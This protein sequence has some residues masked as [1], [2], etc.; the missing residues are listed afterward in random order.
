MADE[1]RALLRRLPARVFNGEVHQRELGLA[2]LSLLVHGRLRLTFRHP[3]GDTKKTDDLISTEPCLR[4]KGI[5]ITQSWTTM[6]P[7]PALERIPGG[8]RAAWCPSVRRSICLPPPPHRRWSCGR[9]RWFPETCSV[10]GRWGWRGLLWGWG[11]PPGWRPRGQARTNERKQVCRKY[12]ENF[13]YFEECRQ[14][15]TWTQNGH[16]SKYRRV[17]QNEPSNAWTHLYFGLN[18]PFKRQAGA[19]FQTARSHRF[20]LEK[21]CHLVAGLALVGLTLPVV[22]HVV[23]VCQDT[24]QQLFGT[25]HHM[26][27]W[28]KWPERRWDNEFRWAAQVPRA[29][30]E[31]VMSR[32][33]RLEVGRIH[34]IALI[35][36]TRGQLGVS[37]SKRHLIYA[38]KPAVL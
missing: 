26:F 11:A 18:W 25:P 32:L 7:L 3:L 22:G 34:Q 36:L 31:N 12:S 21:L 30:L 28:N 37:E 27:V 29:R 33:K 20:V 4:F 10:G 15:N 14:P 13:R 6:K 2:V 35:V 1:H 9:S 8:C 16:F 38:V 5:K 24:L 17:P 23:D 19:W